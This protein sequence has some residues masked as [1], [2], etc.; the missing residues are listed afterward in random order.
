MTAIEQIQLAR[1]ALD[2]ALALL[3]PVRITD[4]VAR[5]KPALPALGPA[6]SQFTD[7]TFGSRITRIT[8]ATISGGSWRVPSNTHLAAWNADGTA[9]YVLGG[10]GEVR[11]YQWGA[12]GARLIGSPYSQVEPCFSRTAPDVLYTNG[13]A[14]ART[15]RAYS[16]PAGTFADLLDVDTL[17]P[18]LDGTY[19][20]GLLHAAGA[21]VVFFGGAGADQ[22]HY[23]VRWTPGGVKLLDTLPLGYRLHSVSVDLYG[24][25]VLLYPTNAKPYQVIVWDTQ[26]NTTTP[27][28]VATS[29]HDALGFGMLI[30]ADVASGPWDAAQWCI[31]K[32][33]NLDHPTNLIPEVLTPKAIG[34]ADHTSWPGTGPIFSGTYRNQAVEPERPWRAWDDEILRIPTDGTGVVERLAHHRSDST[35]GFWNQ[36]IVNADPTGRFVLFTSNWEK[37]LG[38]DPKG[39]V[40]QD[41]FL[42][43]LT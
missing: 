32:L 31:R 28:T 1:A 42:L 43:E 40:R 39:Q 26:T 5:P 6:G 10:G 21:L 12:G 13:G 30:N 20:G 23:V 9:F 16:L 37:T 41:V 17:V 34:L 33:S 38:L 11:L 3:Q 22:H 27:M 25:Y 35:P 4:R 2:Q 18:G 19:L 15:I 7:P 14:H 29:G 8:D 24:R 36:P